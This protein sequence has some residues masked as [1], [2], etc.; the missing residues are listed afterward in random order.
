MNSKKNKKEENETL[1]GYPHYP[2]SED[3]LA[4][5][6]RVDADVENLSRS[7]KHGVNEI[8][9]NPA[10]EVKVDYSPEIVEGTEAD[11]T[12]DDLRALGSLD[13][14]QDG[15]EDETLM[16]KI[17]IGPDLFGED[18]DVPGSELD[19]DAEDIGSEDEGNNYYSRGQD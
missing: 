17:K 2:E 10:E 8:K 16:T 5:E 6:N 18:L 7:H 14:D 15:G 12:P 13:G 19:D 4:N 11:L 1:P 9:Q 3:I